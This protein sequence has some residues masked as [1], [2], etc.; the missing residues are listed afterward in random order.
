[1]REA[2]H[3]AARAPAKGGLP[4]VLFG[5]A[6][7]EHLPV[8]LEGRAHELRVTLPWGSLL[9]GALDPDA[10]FG[11]TAARLLRPGGDLRLMLSV[12]SRDGIPGP[13]MSD[14][15][16][17]VS[18]ARLYT[19]RGWRM[20]EARA[21]SEEDVEACA[22]SWARRLGIPGRRPAAVLRLERPQRISD[23]A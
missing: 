4:N 12:T 7:A 8:E 3:R 20:L 5:V 13:A 19:E 21:A 2:S 22:S 6:T 14:A 16:G 23:A 15:A 9:R 17:A 11:A 1:M 10:W 18:L